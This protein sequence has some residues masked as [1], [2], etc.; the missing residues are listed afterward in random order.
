MIISRSI[1]VATIRNRPPYIKNKFMV[2]E[3][4]RGGR[5]TLDIWDWHIHSTIFKIYDK[6]GSTGWHRV[7][8]SM[9]CNNI[10]GKRI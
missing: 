3:G 5:D 8:S 4:E 10:N 6:E 9:F 1:H 7:H 2:T